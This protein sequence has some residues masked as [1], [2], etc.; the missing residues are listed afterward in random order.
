[1]VD[2]R[3]GLNIKD[4]PF[5][6][7]IATLFSPSILSETSQT[8]II[9]LLLIGGMLGSLLTI[10]NPLSLLIKW[11]YKREYSDSIDYVIM[12]EL[13]SKRNNLINKI[14]TKNFDAALSSPMISFETDKII[15]MI[16]FVIILALTIIRSFMGDFTKIFEEYGLALWGIRIVAIF[17][18]IGVVMVLLHHVYG[19]NFKLTSFDMNFAKIHKKQFQ[20]EELSQFNRIRSVTIAN[21]AMD[22]ANLTNDGQKW[23]G[24]K[25][26][27]ARVN[28]I[29]FRGMNRVDKKVG[30]ILSPKWTTSLT[31]FEDHFKSEEKVNLDSVGFRILDDPK[32]ILQLYQNYKLVKEISLRYGVTF[33]QALSWFYNPVFF[34]IGQLYEFES[35]LKGYVESRDWY[36]AQLLEYRIIDMM[37]RILLQKNMPQIIDENWNRQEYVNKS[38]VK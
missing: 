25:L 24:T 19:M 30:K 12:P 4:F 17:G 20:L 35:Q 31:D 8:P 13:T 21:L 11:V 15:A 1:M 36:S 18:I 28:D 33:S 3:G 10:I 37:T 38:T 29:I 27:N 14:C 5:A 23:S 9:G 7:S 26:S 22:F 2:G 16:Y 6:F 32:T 34:D